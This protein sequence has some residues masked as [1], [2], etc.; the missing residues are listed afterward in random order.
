MY[1]LFGMYGS[2]SNVHIPRDNATGHNKGFCFVSMVNYKDA[3]NAIQNL[4]G[5][6]LGNKFLK[7]SFKTA[8]K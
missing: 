6:Q 4:N 7:V 5:Y 8:N 1:T 3:E 2:V